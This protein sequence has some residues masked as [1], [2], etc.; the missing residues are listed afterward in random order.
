MPAHRTRQSASAIIACVATSLIAAPAIAQRSRGIDVSSWQGTVN[1]TSVR[2]SG[3]DFAFIRSTR[4][5]TTGTYNQ[6]DPNNTLGGNTLS[7]S[8][9]DTRFTANITGARNAGIFAGPYHFSRADILTYVDNGVTVTHTG[10]D[11]ANHMLNVAG[12]YMAM[13]YLRPV[14]DLEAGGAERTTT[15]LTNFALDFINRIVAVKGYAPIVYI[16]TSYANDQVDNRLRPYDLWLARY[17]DPAAVN[18]QT[19]VDPPTVGAY[20]NVYGVWSTYTTANPVHPTPRPWDFWQYTSSGTTPGVSGANDLNVAN[21]DIEFVKDFLVPALWQPDADGNWTTSSNWNGSSAQLLPGPNDRVTI[22]KPGVRIVTLSTGAQSVRS[23]NLSETL[24]ITGGSLAMSQDAI[25]NAGGGALRIEAGAMNARTINAGGRIDLLGGTLATTSTT[26]SLPFVSSDVVW[27]QGG[28]LTIPNGQFKTLTLVG[29]TLKLTS[30]SLWTTAETFSLTTNTGT[31]TAPRSTLDLGRATLLW[32][33][34]VG[35]AAIATLTQS[36]TGLHDA[37]AADADPRYTVGYALAG[38]LYT[39]LPTVAGG[40]SVDSSSILFRRVLKGDAN[41]DGTVNFDDLLKL[42]S[43][44]NG[45][46]T[47]WTG[48][49][50]NYDGAANFDDLLALASNYNAS[51][52]SAGDWSLATASVPEPTAF[53][54]VAV[55]VA[56]AL[57]RRPR[58]PRL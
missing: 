34:P 40:V 29:G 14:Y 13:G 39:T 1:W 23:L 21:G 17:I 55:G 16:N 53:A 12:S 38:E 33:Y 5:G 11:E 32:N 42:A 43:N 30:T 52:S 2:N 49:D 56:S 3:V 46:D 25:V 44:Y 45:V 37:L 10:T 58:M 7:Q 26:S 19:V 24:R 15:S 9:T 47:F 41:L 4:G 27:L 18:V 35:F 57:A 36:R 31:G 28:S 22:S 48:G 50:F 6:S 8:F 20:P 51:V 54:V